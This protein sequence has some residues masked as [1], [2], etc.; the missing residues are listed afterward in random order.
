MDAESA[1]APTV[2]AQLQPR[3]IEH[4]LGHS[5]SRFSME[6]PAHISDDADTDAASGLEDRFKS[7]G[8]LESC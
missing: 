2:D 6:R 3:A 1:T 8:S 4:R 5:T 7:T